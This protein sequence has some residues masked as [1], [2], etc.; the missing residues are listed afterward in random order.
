MQART[1][2]LGSTQAAAAATAPHLGPRLSGVADDVP[3]P[4]HD[5]NASHGLQ[6]PGSDRIH[7]ADVSWGHRDR[8]GGESGPHRGQW[9]RLGPEQH[10]G[11]T[12]SL[13]N[14][15]R[16]LSLTCAKNNQTPELPP[17]GHLH[18]GVTHPEWSWG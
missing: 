5:L 12:L 16:G 6:T 15:D 1:L 10:L 18:P 7:P 11:V 17:D 2:A 9:C 4:V 3:F 8:R 14:G 13:S